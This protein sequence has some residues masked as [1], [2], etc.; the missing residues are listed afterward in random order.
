MA[1][2][3]GGPRIGFALALALAGALLM[4]S[5]LATLL[6]FC[7]GLLINTFLRWMDWL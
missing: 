7:F 3:D 5:W 1:G 4:A 6:A 2:S